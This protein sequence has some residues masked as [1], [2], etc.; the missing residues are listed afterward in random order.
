MPL[1][2][3]SLS[4]EYALSNQKIEYEPVPPDIVLSIAPLFCPHEDAVTVSIILTVTHVWKIGFITKET[5]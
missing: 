2:N 3:E 5:N 4:A 1:F